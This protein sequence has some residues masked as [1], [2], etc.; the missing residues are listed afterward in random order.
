[1]RRMAAGA[2]LGILAAVAAMPAVAQEGVGDLETCVVESATAEDRRALV[3]WMFSAISLHA[4]LQDLP[5]LTP[6]QREEVNRGM[7][8]VMERLLVQDCA[9]QARQAFR[10]GNADQAVGSAFRRV[11][12]LAGE[13]LF[14][15]T[16]VA[17]EAAGLVR[18]VDMNRIVEL[19]LP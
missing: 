4:E 10:D 12:E 16:R 6:A 14:A 9:A 1:M 11:G 2:M 18:H 19:F 13:G 3:R 17:A 15:D 8:A 7:G 5:Q